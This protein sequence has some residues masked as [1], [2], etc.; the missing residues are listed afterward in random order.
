MH[1][2]NLEN[3]IQTVARNKQRKF[4]RSPPENK[5]NMDS[6]KLNKGEHVTIAKKISNTRLVYYESLH[7]LINSRKFFYH[8][9]SFIN[10]KL[11]SKIN[12]C[13][14]IHKKKYSIRPIKI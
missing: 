13:L 3:E 11:M 12:F 2:N 1:V 6:E 4:W 8:R 14:N 5:K 9:T 7:L 10:D